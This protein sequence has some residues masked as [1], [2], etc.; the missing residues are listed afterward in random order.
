MATAASWFSDPAR[1]PNR[2]RP[3]NSA[4]LVAGASSPPDDKLGAS[5]MEKTESTTAA[6][7]KI[8][9]AY[10]RGQGT[11]ES[12]PNYSGSDPSLRGV[13]GNFFRQF[14]RRKSLRHLELSDRLCEP[15]YA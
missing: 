9:S 15:L 1:K 7:S 10:R 13:G 5:G 14:P 6:P 12:N 3:V 8:E 2:S 11:C 4:P